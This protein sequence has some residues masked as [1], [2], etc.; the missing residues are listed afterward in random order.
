M[1]EPCPGFKSGKDLVDD[2]RLICEAGGERA[3]SRLDAVRRG[4]Q[5]DPPV[6]PDCLHY[7]ALLILTEPAGLVN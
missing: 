4:W 3:D 6:C 2:E 1:N 7:T 5:L